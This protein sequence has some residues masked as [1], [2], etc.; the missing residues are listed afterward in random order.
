VALIALRR[1]EPAWYDPSFR[2][3]GYPAVPVLGAIGSFGMIAF[4]QLASQ[5]I[6]VA[7]MLATAGW[8]GY[9]ARDVELKGVL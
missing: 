9:Y 2:V 3:P 1:N 5:L 6:G 4:M 8:Y 7:I